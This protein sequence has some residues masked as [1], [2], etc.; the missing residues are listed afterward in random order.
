MSEATD[1]QS[2]VNVASTFMRH[3]TYGA[4]AALSPTQIG[5]MVPMRSIDS[6]LSGENLRSHIA[7]IFP[8]AHLFCNEIADMTS[9]WMEL[10]SFLD[11]CGASL[12]Q[13]SSR[14]FI[15]TLAHGLYQETEEIQPVD[16]RQ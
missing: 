6:S 10:R 13:H 1:S 2:E 16:H 15:L 12:Q 8:P 5:F 9:V 3:I 7:E 11:A 14:R 4:L